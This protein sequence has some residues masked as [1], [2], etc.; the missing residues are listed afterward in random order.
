MNQAHRWICRSALWR[1][2]MQK[3]VLPWVLEDITLGDQV[4]EVG[5]GPGVT[6]DALRCCSARVTAV[7]IDVDLAHRLKSR[8]AGSNVVVLNADATALPLPEASFT[9]AVSFTML[10]HVPS[11]SLQNKLFAEVFR[12]LKPGGVLVGSDSRYSWGMILLHIRDTM[13]LVDPGGL[14]ARLKQ[15]GFE[16]VAVEVRRRVFRFRAC[17]PEQIDSVGQG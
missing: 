6:T 13:V 15:V 1:Y 10:H 4:L 17:K 8:F 5:P 12:V 14:A 2:S 7:E 9:S 3:R 11:Q 16:S